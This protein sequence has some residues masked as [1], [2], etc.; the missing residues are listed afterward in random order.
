M[1][2]TYTTYNISPKRP[3]VR[4]TSTIND[5]VIIIITM[6]D[7]ISIHDMYIHTN[8]IYSMSNICHS[9]CSFFIAMCM[10]VFCNEEGIRRIFV[11]G[12]Q[13]FFLIFLYIYICTTSTMMLSSSCLISLA[14]T[15][16]VHIY[17]I[18]IN[19]YNNI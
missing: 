5:V 4:T 13:F 7:F 9:Y 2:A 10:C 6:L 15:R 1:L 14:H 19:I 12:C 16:H 8:I 18:Y 11:G 17:I 3:Y